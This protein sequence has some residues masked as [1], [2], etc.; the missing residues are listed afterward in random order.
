MRSRISLE[1]HD[2]HVAGRPDVIDLEG[3][4]VLGIER[5]V[6]AERQRVAGEG[7]HA[8]LALD[9]VG[10]ADDGHLNGILGLS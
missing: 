4:A 5:P 6:V 3:A 1:A 7:F 10:G 8:Q 2:D 9:A